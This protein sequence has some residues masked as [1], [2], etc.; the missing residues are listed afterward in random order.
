MAA[1]ADVPDVEARL[2]RGLSG[3]EITAAL[4]FL[5]EASGLA[6]RAIPGL[7]AAV[8]VDLD[9]AAV[10]A[11]KIAGAVVRV[12]RNPSGLNFEQIGA[13]AY[14]RADAVADGSLY[15]TAEELA[16]M[17][18]AVSAVRRVGSQKLSAWGW[19]PP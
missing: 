9:L 19:S 15:L 6:R 18:P 3:V 8:V 1:L 11:G 4:V 13:Y 14:R 17:R 10:V 12:L 16:Q 7:D 5:D 2:Q